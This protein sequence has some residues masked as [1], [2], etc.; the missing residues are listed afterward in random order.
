MT[1]A[2]EDRLYMSA[3]GVRRAIGP[4]DPEER[5]RLETLAAEEYDR[6]HPDDSFEALMRRA[7]FSKEDQGLLKD[8]LAAA[9]ARQQ[10]VL[11]AEPLRRA[12]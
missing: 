3:N 6:C 5:A 8:W 7:R 4:D 12:A 9:A 2:A 10:A 11:P 1:Q